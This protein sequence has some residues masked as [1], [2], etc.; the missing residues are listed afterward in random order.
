MKHR[1]DAFCTPREPRRH[2]SVRQLTR[3]ILVRPPRAPG[4][5]PEPPASHPVSATRRGLLVYRTQD[6]T[7]NLQEINKPAFDPHRSAASCTSSNIGCHAQSVLSII[8]QL[9]HSAHSGPGFN[10]GKQL[11]FEPRKSSGTSDCFPMMVCRS[12]TAKHMICHLEQA[13]V[14]V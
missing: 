4:R 10:C 11:H 14:A 3:F 1:L 12:A 5:S 13:E 2:R 6:T 8:H 7:L 9:T